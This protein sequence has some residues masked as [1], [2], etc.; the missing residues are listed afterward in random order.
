MS[1]LSDVIKKN[2]KQILTDSVLVAEEIFSSLDESKDV[3]S[4]PIKNVKPP[5][6]PEPEAPEPEES[7]TPEVPEPK[8]E[9]PVYMV[10]QAKAQEIEADFKELTNLREIFVTIQK[11]ID[12]F[13]F[14]IQKRSARLDKKYKNLQKS[15]GCPVDAGYELIVATNKQEFSHFR[16]KDDPE[17]KT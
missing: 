8:K 15:C 12:L 14:F 10:D 13:N 7:K 11:S 3:P 16:H 5:E 9:F 17:N 2:F 6:V 1:I 4:Y